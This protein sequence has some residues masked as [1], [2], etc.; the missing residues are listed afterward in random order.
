MEPD[1][2]PEARI[3]ELER[4]LSE[5]AQHSEL[6]VT[7]RSPYPPPVYSASQIP[8]PSVRK[9]RRRFVLFAA[10]AI[11]GA[12]GLI[13]Y[14]AKPTLPQ[15]NPIGSSQTPTKPLHSS[16]AETP[17][18]ATAAPPSTEA[19]GP[20]FVPPGSTF[21]VSGSHKQVAVNCD[22]CSIN[23]SGVSN[24]VEVVGN[25]DTLTVS[26]IENTVN[27][28]TAR[29]IDTSGFDNKVTYYFGEPEVAKSGDRNTVQQG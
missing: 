10:V 24:T 8:R 17:T 15:D 26:G 29:K 13:F 12:A 3:R 19:S 27:V 2:D 11:A 6:G 14:S 23:V 21:S 16:P 22:N 20:T 28:E 18:R 1:G 7:N 25:C 4:S 9:V 5:R